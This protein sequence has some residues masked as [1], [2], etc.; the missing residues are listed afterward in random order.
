MY[1]HVHNNLVSS[2]TRLSLITLT[3][4]FL[5]GSIRAGQS[6][7]PEFFGICSR[8]SMHRSHP[9]FPQ[10]RDSQLLFLSPLADAL[11]NLESGPLVRYSYLRHRCQSVPGCDSGKTCIYGICDKYWSIQRPMLCPQGLNASGV[12]GTDA[13]YAEIMPSGLKLTRGIASDTSSCMVI[14]N[15]EITE[16]HHVAYTLAQ[17]VFPEII[18]SP[19]QFPIGSLDI[20]IKI[21]TFGLHNAQYMY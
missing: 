11:Q 12:F 17:C 14:W 13:K 4:S 20:H 1:R 19:C 16:H 9:H 7:F 2:L 10:H 8:S 21:S 3:L 18:Y 6:G 5:V 15:H